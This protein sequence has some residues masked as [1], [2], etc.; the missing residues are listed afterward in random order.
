[1]VKAL[2]KNIFIETLLAK[3][4]FPFTFPGFEIDFIYSMV[5]VKKFAAIANF[6]HGV[7]AKTKERAIVNSC[8]LIL[9][10]EY[11]NLFVLPALQ[12]GAGTSLN[13]NVNEA[14]AFVSRKHFNVMIDPIEDINASQST[15]DVNPT[16]LRI[17]LLNKSHRV[18]RSSEKL[19]QSI[20]DF[21]LKNINTHKV[22]RT[23]L[24]D[25][26]TMTNHEEWMA[27]HGSIKRALDNFQIV[28]ANLKE[29][30]IG[31]T[32]IGNG[33]NA[34]AGY[35]QRMCALL[36]EE[37][38]IGFNVSDSKPSLISSSGSIVACSGAIKLLALEI[39][40]MASDIRLLSSGPNA[41]FSEYKLERLQRGSTIMPGKVNP[42]IPEV[43]NQ[44]YY[45]ISGNDKTI[46]LCAENAQLQ[47]S[48]MSPVMFQRI[49]ESV[50]LL[51]EAMRVFT[52]FIKKIRINTSKQKE[53]TRNSKIDSATKNSPKNGYYTEERKLEK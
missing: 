18:V 21:A 53:Y 33:V 32:A 31:G 22:S 27:W 15:N 43:V 39:S 51:D 5:L 29:L 34:P 25:A 48:A 26:L 46:E 14:I 30:P 10:G 28:F 17:Y 47:L 2:D 45:V 16:A 44:A 40:K 1:M 19:L 6:E 36:S 11:S 49:I 3:K 4:N 52:P 41:G 37:L 7:L 12:G 42:V 23:H 24:Q 35:D 50:V 38:K 8:D 9:S 13:M 20:Y